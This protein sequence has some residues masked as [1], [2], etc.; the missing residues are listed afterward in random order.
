MKAINDAGGI[1]GRKINARIEKF[2]PLD[3][4]RHALEVQ[5]LDDE[6]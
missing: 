4:G 2:N 5:G 1:N 3:A 6:R